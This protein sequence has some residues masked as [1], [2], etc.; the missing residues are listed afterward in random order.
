MAIG[1]FPGVVEKQ[2][3][4]RYQKQ[5][6]P[7]WVVFISGAMA[8]LI[9]VW[10]FSFAGVPSDSGIPEP[11]AVPECSGGAHGYDPL[12]DPPEG[13]FYDD[14]EVGYTFGS[15]IREWDEK[16][17]R[18]F[19]LHPSFAVGAEGR[20][21]MVTGSQPTPCRNPI[22]D[23]LL[24]RLFKNKVDYCRIHGCDVFYN[25]VLLQ[26]EMFTF[27]AKYPAI[28][29]AM[30]AHPEA[31]WIWWVDSDAAITDMDF[32][33]PLDRYRHHNLVVHGWQHVIVDER[34]WTGLNAG[35][36]LIRNCQWSLDL[37]ALWAGMG[38]QSPDYDR[39]G[40]LQLSI[41]KDKIAPESDD[42]TALAYIILQDADQWTEKI[43]LEGEYYFQGYWVDIVGKLENVTEKYREIESG[44]RRLR[45]RRAEK[46]NEGYGALWE[47]YLKLEGAGHG[48]RGWRRPFI[49]HFTG[50]QPCSGNHNKAYVGNECWD[51]MIK[52]LNFADDQVLR[53]FGYAH[54]GLM[55][56]SSVVPLP[57]D[58]PSSD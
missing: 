56:S 45:R 30:V 25:N 31:E 7:N 46:V 35:V 44:A 49:T 50:C 57:F 53:S 54:A 32:K 3:M 16:R 19:E 21:I 42:Q 23:H 10:S 28:R 37:M 39:W 8:S 34:S 26:P 1:I 47:E 41:F 14:P 58:Y 15:K 38:P 2:T 52:A 48:T 17:K 12:H 9:V 5:P 36:F 13:T 40:E 18:W 29:A 55:N 43:Y 33:L 22:G 6:M 51:G 24:L 27:W 4:I 20:V 11:G